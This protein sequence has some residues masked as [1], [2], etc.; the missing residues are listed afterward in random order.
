MRKQRWKY[1]MLGALIVVAVLYG[2]ELTS[3]GLGDVYGPLDR[4]TAPIVQQDVET[5]QPIAAQ[6]GE[7]QDP[8][9]QPIT[10]IG[11][12]DGEAQR[13][14]LAEQGAK[15]GPL[16]G[17][18]QAGPSVAGDSSVNRLADG[19]AGLLQSVTSGGIRLV[20]S[21]FEAITD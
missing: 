2:I 1:G 19:T 3:Q 12:T 18:Q 15:P 5:Q 21:M 14:P 20:V 7:R 9:Q 6:G 17:A 16:T 11:G 13:E 4:G 10:E 8:A